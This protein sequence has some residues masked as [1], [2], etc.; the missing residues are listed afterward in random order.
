MYK[1]IFTDISQ[2]Q[3]Y[4][5][6]SLSHALSLSLSHALSPFSLSGKLKAVKRKSEKSKKITLSN[7]AAGM[8]KI[9]IHTIQNCALKKRGN[10]VGGNE[11]RGNRTIY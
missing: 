10:S 6:V 8:L 3:K 4:T 11:T 9:T 5:N 7:H 2:P 1:Y